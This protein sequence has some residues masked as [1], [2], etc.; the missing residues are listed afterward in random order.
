MGTGEGGRNTLYH[1]LEAQLAR[2]TPANPTGLIVVE[3]RNGEPYQ[4]R[5]MSA[6]HRETCNAAELP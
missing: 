1:E 2:V 6:V 4:H 5:R 3:D